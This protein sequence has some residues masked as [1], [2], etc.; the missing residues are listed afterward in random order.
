MRDGFVRV[1]AVTPAIRV[2]DVDFNVAS[3]AAAARHASAA[4]ARV[5]V[6]PE[7]TIT[8]YTCEDL[9]WQDALLNAAE[10]GLAR[11]AHETADIDALIFVGVPVRVAAKLYNCAAAVCHGRVLGLVPKRNIPTYN[12]FYEGR[13]FCAGP[14]EVAWVRLPA[15]GDEA[16]PFGSHLLFTC[17]DMP[18]LVVGAE[19]C[20]DLWVPNPPSTEQALA[21]ATLICN[22]SA[23]NELVGK[24]GYRRSL[25]SSTSARLVCAYAYASAGWGESTQ[26]LVFGGH[27]LVGENG[28]ILAQSEPFAGERVGGWVGGAPSASNTATCGSQLWCGS[29]ACAAGAVVE[30][31]LL[32]A[33]DRR[34]M[35]TFSIA[36][37]ASGFVTVPFSLEP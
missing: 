8:A 32:L 2:A 17:E 11:F 20:E 9:F 1:A 22:L 7:L 27:C 21:G 4:G 30:V 28:R 36:P 5:I 10:A 12:E 35:S 37:D 3:C 18:E 26:D 13:H 31:D 19:V 34:R 33:A 29:E 25:V 6:L 16:I 23:S 15:L 14:A 24:A